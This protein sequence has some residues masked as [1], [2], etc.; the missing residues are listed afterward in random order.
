[1]EISASNLSFRGS[2]FEAMKKLPKDIGIEVFIEWGNDYYWDKALSNVMEKRRGP[3]SIHGPIRFV[4]FAENADDKFLFDYMKWVFKICKKHNAEFVVI[5]PNSSLSGSQDFCKMR[6]Y[7]KERIAKLQKMAK[8]EDVALAIENIP[9]SNGE[10]LFD[11]K[12]YIKIFKDIPEVKS[13][14]DIGHAFIENWDIEKLLYSL[15]DRIIAYHIHDNNG[16]D[17]KHL[18]IGEGNF[19]WDTFFKAFVKYTPDATL[20]LEYEETTL[21]EIKESAEYIKSKIS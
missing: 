19:D 18:K 20:V 14:I 8:Q 1:M 17:D 2:S 7:S 3:L 5:H 9:K 6:S 4:D 13:L 10:I 16:C 15:K 12:E 21:E 11:I